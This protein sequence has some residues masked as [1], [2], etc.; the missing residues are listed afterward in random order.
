MVNRKSSGENAPE[1]FGGIEVVK[2]SEVEE[3][4]RRE[5]TEVNELLTISKHI[6]IEAPETEQAVSKMLEE[7]V[8]R[9]KKLDKEKKE[10][11]Q[12][13]MKSLDK[14]RS[15]FK[16]TETAL[17]QVE[18]TLKDA[19]LDYRRRLRLQAEAAR[20]EMAKSVT[21]A[22]VKT[23][24]AKLETSAPPQTQGLGVSK[25]W[26]FVVTDESLVPRE[27][28]K[29]DETLIRKAIRSGVREIPGVHISQEEQIA[30]K[31]ARTST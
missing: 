14:I 4:I 30:V 26:M 21:P 28:F 13:L 3:L 23:A 25:V 11:T 22:E 27:Y 16:P 12:P 18:R 29:L 19:V 7:I 31:P 6:K 5:A 1:V 24:I 17:A 15:W 9:A 20:V 8:E 10:A 2:T